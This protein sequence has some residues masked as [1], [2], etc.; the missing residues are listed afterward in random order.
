MSFKK[1]IADLWYMLTYPKSFLFSLLTISYSPVISQQKLVENKDGRA[2][3]E[4]YL[5]LHVE[6]LWLSGQHVNWQTGEPDDPSAEQDIHT[7]CSAF[8]A[9]ACEKKNIY[10][11]RPPDHSI[12]LLANA[13]YDW[14]QSDQAKKTGWVK[15]ESSGVY[16]KAQVLANQGYIVIATCRNKN[17]KLPGH[18]ALV[19]PAELTTD[20]LS[21]SGPM[22]ISAGTHNFNYISL[23]SAFSS[24]LSGWPE[25]EVLFFY[26][27]SR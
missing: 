6:G 7:H 10:L 24:H 8:V 16:E 11:L 14:L 26:F 13:Q 12:Q 2:L 23:K 18:I 5:S 3:K 25:E 4:F 9:A 21:G 17:P 27:K 15:I 20:Q 1:D 19:R 22:L